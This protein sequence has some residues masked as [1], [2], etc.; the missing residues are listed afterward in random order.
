PGLRQL[1]K[2]DHFFDDDIIGV[3]I[4][5]PM[6]MMVGYMVETGFPYDATVING[7]QYYGGLLGQE[8]F[9]P[10]DVAGW[11]GNHEW[12]NS[13]TLTGRWLII[14]YFNQYVYSQNAEV[15]RQFAI[16]VVGG[17]S[18]D[19]EIVCQR[20]IDFLLPRGMQTAAD[21][22]QATNV[23][24][25]VYPANYYTLGLWNLNVEFAHY[26][27]FLLLNHIARTPEFQLT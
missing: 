12:I 11:Q 1:F 4:K 13:S 27:V 9:N 25:D 14:D 7:T 21:Y 10:V 6:E 23:F 24:K 17:V 19:P 16:D 20:I 8:I 22:E 15:F 2:S 18:S 5:S 26:Q 3:N